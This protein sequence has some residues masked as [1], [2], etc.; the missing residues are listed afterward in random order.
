LGTSSHKLSL[1]P[2]IK[3]C[4]PTQSTPWRSSSS[5]ATTSRAPGQCSPSIKWVPLA[6]AAGA[7]AGRAPA[8]ASLVARGPCCAW[9]VGHAAAQSWICQRVAP[10]CASPPSLSGPSAHLPPPHPFHRRPLM[11]SRTCSCSRSSSSKSTPPPSATTSASPSATTCCPSAL[12]TTA[13]GS[14]TTRCG[15]ACSSAPRPARGG[16]H[17]RLC[18][19]RSR[20]IKRSQSRPCRT[21]RSRAFTLIDSAPFCVI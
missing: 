14:G 7:G 16:V 6:W 9:S 5:A 3:C 13:S 8:S 20:F 19:A 17:A 11:S 1:Y 12:P 4:P 21:E 10:A 18:S 2:H 15:W